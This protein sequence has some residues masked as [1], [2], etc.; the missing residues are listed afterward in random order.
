MSENRKN[1]INTTLGGFTNPQVEMTKNVV[2][3]D[4]WN[5][6][7]YNHQYIHVRFFESGTVDFEEGL[8]MSQL[9]GNQEYVVNILCADVK[10]IEVMCWEIYSAMA[11][12]FCKHSYLDGVRKWARKEGFEMKPA[13]E[14]EFARARWAFEQLE[15]GDFVEK[16]PI[17]VKLMR[18]LNTLIRTTSPKFIS[19]LA[20]DIKWDLDDRAGAESTKTAKKASDP[21][22]GSKYATAMTA[23]PFRDFNRGC[24]KITQFMKTF[25]LPSLNKFEDCVNTIIDNYGGDEPGTGI[26][27]DSTR[28]HRVYPDDDGEVEGW[29]K[30]S[31]YTVDNEGRMVEIRKANAVPTDYAVLYV[32]VKVNVKKEKLLLFNKYHDSIKNYVIPHWERHRKSISVI[33][34]N[35][36]M[37][38][39]TGLI[40]RIIGSGGF[41]T[42]VD[43]GSIIRSIKNDE[44]FVYKVKESIRAGKMLS[45]KERLEAAKTDSLKAGYDLPPE[46]KRELELFKARSA[47]SE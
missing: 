20:K 3:I 17:E 29:G 32:K 25:G 15:C 34:R 2:G 14:V 8:D 38:V 6:I 33:D 12:I 23:F 7:L 27:I 28:T 43:E 16:L 44:G 21:G 24:S 47:I 5:D 13:E 36:E 37:D 45:M 41:I 39:V 30:T 26:H 19:L 10:S 1:I 40:A 31:F 18:Y 9:Y 11:Q 4:P 35:F 42:S 46:Y 22:P